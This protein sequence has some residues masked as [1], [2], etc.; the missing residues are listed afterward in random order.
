M[1]FSDRSQQQCEVLLCL[2]TVYQLPL[3]LILMTLWFS[4]LVKKNKKTPDL[5]ELNTRLI[6]A[7][8]WWNKALFCL[9]C[10]LAS[11]SVQEESK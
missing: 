3:G 7:S 8:L 4:H 2:L 5:P 6:N 9:L 1:V 11:V 10:Q